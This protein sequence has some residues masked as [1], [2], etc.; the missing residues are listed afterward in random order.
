MKKI[1]VIIENKPTQEAIK[2]LTEYLTKVAQNR[3]YFF[4]I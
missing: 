4:L 1:K 3:C 2:N